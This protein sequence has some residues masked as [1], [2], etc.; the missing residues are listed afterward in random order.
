MVNKVM[1]IGNLTQPPEF[2]QLQN[3]GTVARVKLATNKSWKDRATGERKTAAE[4]AKAHVVRIMETDG[5][6]ETVGS[7][8]YGFEADCGHHV[9][10]TL[11]HEVQHHK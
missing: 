7:Y 8:D 4:Y 3:G 11:I 10:S 1:L 9:Y 6:S 5:H 2:K